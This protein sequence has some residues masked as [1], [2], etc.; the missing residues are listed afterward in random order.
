MTDHLNTEALQ[1]QQ[2]AQLEPIQVDDSDAILTTN[3]VAPSSDWSEPYL[4][5]LA[6]PEIVEQNAILRKSAEDL[7]QLWQTL[8]TRS[9]DTIAKVIQ[10][11]ERLTRE[12]IELRQVIQQ[13]DRKLA[14][15]EERF[16]E[17]LATLAEFSRNR[18]TTYIS[19]SRP[20]NHLLVHDFI[21]LKDQDFQFVSTLIF[22]WISEQFAD[23][24]LDR[25]QVIA[26]I[27][28][29]LSDL[30]FIQSMSLMS[31]EQE[32]AAATI[33][34]SVCAVFSN[35]KQKLSPMTKELHQALESLI[36]KGLDLVE[37]ITR[38]DPPGDLWMD[39]VGTLFDAERHQPLLGYQSSGNIRLTVYP[40]YRVGNRIFE[41][42]CVLTEK[43]A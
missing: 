34:G 29:I 33:F 12:N 42:A 13:R 9:Q 8:S 24:K 15:T 39:Q 20:Q 19:G 1:D 30:I 18:T 11:N 14:E 5:A 38:A 6:P 7:H 10:E 28:F 27:K 25:K 41:K 3:S 2:K 36:Q 26:K 21:K 37:K 35:Q 23:L 31:V 40:G 16:S 32:D 22:H 43:D 4:E 17:L